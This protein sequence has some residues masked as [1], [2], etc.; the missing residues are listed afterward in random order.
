M[1]SGLR[2]FARLVTAIAVIT[3][4]IAL[5]LAITAGLDLRTRDRFH[6]APVRAAAFVAALDRYADGDVSARAEIL[7]GGAWFEE[8][9]PSGDS[10]SAVSSATADVEKGAVSLARERVAGLV[11]AVEQEQAGLDRQLSSSRATALCWAVPAGVFLAPALWLRRRRRSGVA[12]VVDVV[13]QFVPR[14][15][16][17]QRP[18]FLVFTGVGYGL[19]GMGFFIV[20]AIMPRTDQD[21]TLLPLVRLGLLKVGGTLAMGGATSTLRYCRPRSARDAAQALLADGRQPVLYLR[22]FADDVTAAQADGGEKPYNIYSREEK[23]AAALSTVGPVIAVG[24]PGEPLPRLGA[25]RL[26]LPY[27]DWQPT[28]LRLM[29]LSQLIVFRL[30]PG[31][32]Q[33][34]RWELEQA[35][36]TQPA[37]KLILLLGQPPSTTKRLNEVVGTDNL[38][39][40]A[41]MTF[42][43]NGTAYVD[44]VVPGR[45]RTDQVIRLTRT[46]TSA[47]PID[48]VIRAMKPALASMGIRTRTMVLRTNT[49]IVT[50]GCLLLN[51][52]VAA[53]AAVAILLARAL[54]LV[55]L[56]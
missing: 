46:P 15:P 14:K 22:S 33:G 56:W 30:G 20:T 42:N 36:T 40:S 25:A 29:D 5:H 9:A 47:Q 50:R 10:R 32:G 31:A 28:V 4:Y 1:S 38:W 6:D 11:V 37:R 41:V 26:Y 35:R 8:N 34:L 51:A 48:Q 2:A 3:A 24:K 39:T 7:E 54:Q 53:V 12:E 17:W 23:L 27:D 16:W 21:W 19:F 13:S 52:A 44:P 49:S 43:P 55:G 18:V 45:T